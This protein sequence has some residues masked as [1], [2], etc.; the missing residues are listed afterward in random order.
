[1]EYVQAPV[2]KAFARR[3]GRTRVRRA[4]RPNPRSHPPR[5]RASGR[6]RPVIATDAIFHAIRLEPYLLATAQAPDLAPASRRSR[7]AP[8]KQGLPR[9]RRCQPQEHTRHAAPADVSG[10][11]V[12]LVRRPGVRSRVLPESP[13]P[14][15]PL[16]SSARAALL[17]CYDALSKAAAAP[18]STACR[19]G[20]HRFFQRC[21]LP[22]ST[23]NRRWNT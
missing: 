2:W 11:G 1:M 23:A 20:P 15:M 19:I 3:Q 17:E 21:C 18:L 14:Q 9:A 4:G 5:H 7:N 22:G 12:R 6:Y 10:C 16:G 8:P 13:A